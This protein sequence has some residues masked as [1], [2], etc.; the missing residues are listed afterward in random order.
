MMRNEHFLFVLLISRMFAEDITWL[1]GAFG[2]L[3]KDG[4]SKPRHQVCGPRCLNQPL[5]LLLRDR[6][7][8]PPSAAIRG[9]ASRLARMNSVV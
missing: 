4:W 3:K 1:V 6:V 9:Y 7:F 2:R 5:K 8:D